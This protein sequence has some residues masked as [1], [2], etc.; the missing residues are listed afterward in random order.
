MFDGGAP[1]ING[2]SGIPNRGASALALRAAFGRLCRSGRI[3][4][5]AGGMEAPPRNRVAP[6]LALPNGVW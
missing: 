3:C 4:F 2:D 5:A 6:A 1:F